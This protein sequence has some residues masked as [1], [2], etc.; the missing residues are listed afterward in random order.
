MVGLPRASRISAARS[1]HRVGPGQLLEALVVD[2]DRER[3]GADGAVVGE[4]DQVAVGL[5]ADPLPH[6]PDEVGRAARQLEADQVGAEQAL[7]E[8]AAP[9]QLLEELGR[10]ER[11]VQV[12]A[13]PQVGAELAQQLRA[14][15]GAGSRAPTRS[16]PSRPAPR[17]ARRSA[18]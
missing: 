9:R 5:V 14:R 1:P 8:L 11:D 13:D 15:A 6:Q 4:V 12:E 10:R 7:E 18:G 17:R 2:R 3:R 16:R